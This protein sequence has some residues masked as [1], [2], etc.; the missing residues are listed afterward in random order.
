MD[1]VFAIAHLDKGGG[2]AVQSVQLVRRLRDRVG[3]T[4]LALRAPNGAVASDLDRDAEIV[5]ELSFPGGVAALARQIRARADPRSVVQVFDPYYSLPAARLARARHL[6]VRLGAHPVEDL[7]S[8]YGNLARIGLGALNP[9]LYR[10]AHVVVNAQHLRSAFPGR[11][12]RCIPNGVDMARFARERDP[13]GAREALGLEPG[14][15]TAV[16]VGKLIPRKRVEEVYWLAQQIPSLR[17]VLIGTDQEPYYGDAYHRR[18]RSEFHDVAD[19]VRS[20]GEVPMSA[21]P[22]FL[23]AA[24]LF[25]FPSRLEGMPN[26]VLEAMAAGVPVLAADTPAHREL[27]PEGAGRLFATRPEMLEGALQILTDTGLA[28]RLA[29]RA[30][31]EVEAHHSLEAATEAYLEL[32]RELDGAPRGERTDVLAGYGPH[33]VRAS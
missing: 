4:L 23:E 5:G 13:N 27:L 26:A 20:V 7:A 21:V 18:L 11:A 2:Q 3:G 16:F 25:V 33:E 14:V 12:V 10:G 1:V 6:V 22:Q 15:P 30:R 19:R 32:Y 28:G 8:R 24:D 17:V 31:H 29:S 9:W